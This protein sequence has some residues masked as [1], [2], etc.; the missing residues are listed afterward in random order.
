MSGI[1]VA[2]LIAAIII[3]A[4]VAFMIAMQSSPRFEALMTS[5]WDVVVR[6]AGEPIWRVFSWALCSVESGMQ[7]A[8][9]KVAKR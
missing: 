8:I 4:E 7:A 2:V 9:R 6:Y 3:V 5:I 1:D